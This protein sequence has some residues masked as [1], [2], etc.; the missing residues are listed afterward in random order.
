MYGNNSYGSAPFSGK[1]SNSLI[2][3][4]HAI[5]TLIL[6]TVRRPVILR[7][8]KEQRVFLTTKHK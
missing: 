3:P 7:T 6:R 4:I 2:A 8:K 5:V 1:P